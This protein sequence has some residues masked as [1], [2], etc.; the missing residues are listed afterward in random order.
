MSLILPGFLQQSPV[1]DGFFNANMGPQN[2]KNR[3][4]K[5]TSSCCNLDLRGAQ[6]HPCPYLVGNASTKPGSS[7]KLRQMKPDTLPPHDL[8]MSGF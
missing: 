8:V 3:R 2:E 7:Y 6:W 5:M 1:P 4:D